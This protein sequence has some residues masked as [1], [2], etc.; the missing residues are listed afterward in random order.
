MAA[1]LQ[2]TRQQRKTIGWVVGHGEGDLEQGARRDGFATAR[3]LLE[4]DYYEVRPLSL[5]GA[6]VPPETAVLVIAGPQKDYLD[7]ELAVL[8]RFL[9]RPGHGLVMLDP[10][11][12]PELA[13]AL[14]EFGVVL[15]PDV[16]IEPETSLYGGEAL[17]M[18]IATD[19]RD[20]PIIAPLDTGPLFSLTRSV[21]AVPDEHGTMAVPFLRT[22]AASWATTDTTVLRTGRLAFQVERDRRGPVAVGMEVAF[23]TLTPPGAEPRQGRLVVYG[24]SR[25]AS[26]GFIEYLGNKD[27]F[28]NTVAWLAQDPQSIGHR[29][30]QQELGLQQFFVSTE[31]GNVIFWA[32]AV[33]EPALFA[34]VGLVIAW[35][36]R[37]S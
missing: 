20:H 34:L 36:R 26:N 17:T 33:L 23:R 16:V 12:A 35:R 28:L 29:H 22:S 18:R 1:L 9:E 13:A 6:E 30:R 11:R 5:M 7:E 21:D 25:F 32:A 4:Q 2:V 3:A 31:E 24:T 15:R 10:L 14:E 27:L 19:P 8:R 37:Q